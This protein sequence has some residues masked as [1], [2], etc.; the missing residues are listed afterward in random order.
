MWKN[1]IIIEPS[2][3][4]KIFHSEIISQDEKSNLLRYICYFTEEEKSDL[5]LLI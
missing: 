2:I 5:M 3:K 4:N 1:K